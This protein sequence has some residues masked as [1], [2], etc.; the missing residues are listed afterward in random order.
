MV[1]P[2]VLE[3]QSGVQTA[4]L[5]NTMWNLASCGEADSPILTLR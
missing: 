5:G 1:R 4:F 2:L 3:F